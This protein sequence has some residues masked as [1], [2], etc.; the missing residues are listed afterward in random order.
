MS[1]FSYK[2]LDTELILTAQQAGCCCSLANFIVAL[3]ARARLDHRPQRC[4]PV[5]R[6][7]HQAAVRQLPDSNHQLQPHSLVRLRLEPLHHWQQRAQLG[8]YQA[9][10]RSLL[11]SAPFAGHRCLDPRLRH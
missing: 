10:L 9:D 1:N 7:V 11:G 5:P 2:R 6:Q 8:P 4:S 3:R